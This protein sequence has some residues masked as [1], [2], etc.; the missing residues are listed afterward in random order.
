MKRAISDE[1]A[2]ERMLKAKIKFDRLIYCLEL[3]TEEILH[4]NLEE[5]KLI[6]FEGFEGG[7]IQSGPFECENKGTGESISR[8]DIIQ[9]AKEIIAKSILNELYTV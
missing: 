9:R 6:G 8:A 3:I 5:S 4:L 7:Y 1:R 2:K